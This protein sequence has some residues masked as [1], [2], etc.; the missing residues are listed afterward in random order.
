MVCYVVVCLIGKERYAMIEDACHDLEHGS[1]ESWPRGP[2]FSR[3]N[4]W[5][6]KIQL[7]IL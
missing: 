4:K 2:G 5:Y 6:N 3:L 7:T 1:K